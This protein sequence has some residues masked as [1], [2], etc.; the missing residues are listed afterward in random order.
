M[1]TIFFLK[2]GAKTKDNCYY[3]GKFNRMDCNNLA[4]FKNL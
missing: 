1:S 2:F 4:K 3:I